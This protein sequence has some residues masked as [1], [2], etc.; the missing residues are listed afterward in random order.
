MKRRSLLAST[1]TVLLGASTAGCMQSLGESIGGDDGGCAPGHR[2]LNQNFP[3]KISADDPDGLT[4]SLSADTITPPEPATATLEN[5][6][7]SP[8][9]IYDTDRIAIQWLN[10]SDNWT[11]AIGI[12][13]D[14]TWNDATTSLEVGGTREWEFRLKRGGFP[15]PY[16]RCLGF[17]PGTYR[18]VYWGLPNEQ[19]PLAV[20]FEVTDT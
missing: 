13:E 19:P 11:N 20:P 1:A 9:E 10:S 18:F 8:V 3:S 6:G 2:E 4:L 5:T 15:E 17:V 12:D 14:H 7:D 16:E